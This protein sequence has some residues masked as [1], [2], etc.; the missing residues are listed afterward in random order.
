MSQ[1]ELAIQFMQMGI[2]NP[3]MTDQSLM[4]LDMMDFKGKD[5]LQQKVENMGTLQENLMQV[6]QIAMALAEKYEPG[7]AQQLAGILQGM[8]MDAGLTPG[9]GTEPGAELMPQAAEAGTHSNENSLVRKARAN[10]NESTRP[11]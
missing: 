5:E 9:G 10:V 6:A 8:S 2:F 7:V 11:T 3:Q 4:M 1:N